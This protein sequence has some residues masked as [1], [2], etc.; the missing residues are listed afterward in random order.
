MIGHDNFIRPSAMAMLA[1]TPEGQF[2]QE[3]VDGTKSGL[4]IAV[5]LLRK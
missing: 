4:R 3:L 5:T 1:A 2:A